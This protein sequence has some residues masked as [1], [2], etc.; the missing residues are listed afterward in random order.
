MFKKRPWGR[1]TDPAEPAGAIKY[2]HGGRPR[3]VRGQLV[4]PR[5]QKRGEDPQPHSVYVTT[6]MRAAA[7]CA[8]LYSTLVEPGYIYEVAPLGELEPDPHCDLDRQS[9]CCRIARIKNIFIV[10]P[11]DV[12]AIR[13][14]CA[15]SIAHG[16]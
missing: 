5:I 9:F 12:I 3:M 15:W 14:M 1:A 11:Q 2:F 7:I 16:R 8:A 6:E 10:P 13:I 4:L